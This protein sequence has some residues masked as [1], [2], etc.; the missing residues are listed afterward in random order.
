MSRSMFLQLDL[1]AVC[2]LAKVSPHNVM[3]HDM[4]RGQC[5]RPLWSVLKKKKKKRKTGKETKKNQKEQLKFNYEKY[6]QKLALQTSLI[7][8]CL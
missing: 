1:E 5:N 7:I 4:I 2:S 3:F 8:L 6:R